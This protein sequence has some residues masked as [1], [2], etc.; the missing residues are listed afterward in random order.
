[1]RH[2]I[3]AIWGLALAGSHWLQSCDFRHPTPPVAEQSKF[4]QA[5]ITQL[6][7]HSLRLNCYTPWIDDQGKV[8]AMFSVKDDTGAPVIGLACEN[9]RLFED[10]EPVSKHESF[11]SVTAAPAT[12]SLHTLLLLDVSGSVLPRNLIP[13]KEASRQFVAA[14][15][16]NAS[17]HTSTFDFALYLFAGEPQIVPFIRFSGDVSHILSSIDGLKDGL[18]KDRS[19][20]L[21]GAVRQGV[22][23]LNDEIQKNQA[24]GAAEGAM[25]LFTD[26]TDLAGRFPFD[27]ARVAVENSKDRVL[28]FVIGL[29]DEIDS[30]SL[31][32]LGHSGFAQVDSVEHLNVKFQYLAQKIRQEVEG[33]YLL[34]YCSPKRRGDHELQIRV[35]ATGSETLYSR[36]TVLFSTSDATGGCVIEEGDCKQNP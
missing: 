13:L 26:G 21:H 34:Q 12:Y 15:L 11:F 36:F 31:R 14:L 6:E 5:K 33:R 27:S 25:V 7:S 19:T 10:G 32:V 29:G 2:R 1:M 23:L 9:F 20:D 30:T 3:W 17:T 35:Y 18:I 22:K 4:T 8:L 16:Q 24:P 28:S